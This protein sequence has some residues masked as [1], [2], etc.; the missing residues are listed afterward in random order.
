MLE[1]GLEAEIPAPTRGGLLWIAMADISLPSLV[2]TTSRNWTQLRERKITRGLHFLISCEQFLMS[3]WRNCAEAS[4][5]Q[6]F[7]VVREV[8]AS[9]QADLPHLRKDLQG[10]RSI[11]KEQHRK[12][13]PRR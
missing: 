4:K 9:L 7:Q 8:Q 1:L 13:R 3:L 10:G 5:F 6:S 2:V 12:R 11:V